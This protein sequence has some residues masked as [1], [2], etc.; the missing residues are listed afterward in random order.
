MET[1]GADKT[2]LLREDEES[3]SPNRW[4]T[5]LKVLFEAV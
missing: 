1:S 2:F 4:S 5:T 3:R